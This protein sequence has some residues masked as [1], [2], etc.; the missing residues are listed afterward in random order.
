[1][2]RRHVRYI[3]GSN[4]VTN[5]ECNEYSGDRRRLLSSSATIAFELEITMEVGARD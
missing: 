3:D 4:D 1:V 2:R 5:T